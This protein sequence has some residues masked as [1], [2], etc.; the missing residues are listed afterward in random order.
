M[1]KQKI[2]ALT[3]TVD[4]LKETI[5]AQEKVVSAMEKWNQIIDVERLA[6]NFKTWQSIA[7]EIAQK[8]LERAKDE[9]KEQ[10]ENEEMVKNERIMARLNNLLD[11]YFDAMSFIQKSLY[12]IHQDDRIPLLNQFNFP[13]H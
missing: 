2:D 8:E 11:R 9:I 12:Y 10:F 4:S 7:D 5:L 1:Q 3:N 6:K 13:K